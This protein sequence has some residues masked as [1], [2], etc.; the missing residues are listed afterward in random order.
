MNVPINQ[1]GQP[2]DAGNTSANRA[3]L[4]TPHGTNR[5]RY[6]PRAPQRSDPRRSLRPIIN[7]LMAAIIIHK[8]MYIKKP[9]TAFRL[10]S[11]TGEVKEEGDWDRL[12][13]LIDLSRIRYV[14]KKWTQQKEK[15]K[16]RSPSTNRSRNTR[17]FFWANVCK[18]K[19]KMITTLAKYKS[20]DAANL[21]KTDRRNQFL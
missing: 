7:T 15:Q 3:L 12:T 8:S 17:Q 4:S 21:N 1:P 5:F 14:K 6:D 10:W 2:T 16:I 19:K 9:F 18:R 13:A 11:A 20:N